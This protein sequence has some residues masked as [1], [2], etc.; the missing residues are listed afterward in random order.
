MV[1]SVVSPAGSI[2]PS[3][4]TMLPLYTAPLLGSNRLILKLI[5]LAGRA[6]VAWR[7]GMDSQ[8]SPRQPGASVGSAGR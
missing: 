2:I 7:G 4:L 8:H 6:G 5:S 3:I 1:N